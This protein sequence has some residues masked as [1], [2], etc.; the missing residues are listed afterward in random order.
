MDWVTDRYKSL[1]WKTKGQSPEPNQVVARYTRITYS[2]SICV[3]V[4]VEITITDPLVTSTLRNCTRVWLAWKD[5]RSTP[6]RPLCRSYRL[7]WTDR[8]EIVDAKLWTFIFFFFFCTVAVS[9]C[10]PLSARMS[11]FITVC[12]SLAVPTD[13]IK[14]V[15]TP[16]LPTTNRNAFSDKYARHESKII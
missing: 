6:S 8:K 10:S 11:D 14:H 12:C 16:L 5:E 15:I 2:T 9:A 4:E 7:K 3:C 1:Q 13:L